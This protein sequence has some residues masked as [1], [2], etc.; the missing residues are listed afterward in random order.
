MSKRYKL[1]HIKKLHN[2][3]IEDVLLRQFDNYYELRKYRK[4]LLK[5]NPDILLYHEKEYATKHDCVEFE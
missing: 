1:Y 3:D 4:L 5:L 2:G